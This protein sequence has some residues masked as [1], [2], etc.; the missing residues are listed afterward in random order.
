MAVAKEGC[1][2]AAKVLVGA[3]LGCLGL[4]LCFPKQQLTSKTSLAVHNV[5]FIFAEMA[6]HLCTPWVLQ[7][8]TMRSIPSEGRV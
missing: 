1:T 6:V 4:T 3:C 7:V 2:N 5:S 8:T